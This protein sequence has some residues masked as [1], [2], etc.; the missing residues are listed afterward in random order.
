L[1]DKK[2]IRIS[3]GGIYGFYDTGI[4]SIIKNQYK[5]SNYIFSG[6]SAGA[7]NCLFMS[8]KKD[9]NKLIKSIHNINI[10][11]NSI[12][13]LQSEL[14][15]KILQHHRS[16]DFDLK[17]IFISVC[18]LD[19][20]QFKNFIYTDFV[21]LE[22]V[23]DCCIASSNIPFITGNLINIYRNK[24]T[25]DGGFLTHQTFIFKKP[26]FIIGNGIWGKKRNITSLFS[27][28]NKDLYSIYSEGILDTNLNTNILDTEFDK[29]NYL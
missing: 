12:K 15:N 6:A 14:K 27:K 23:I 29:K 24:I 11:F 19:N 25:F 18:V 10:N 9:I 5:L 26:D 13:Q 28:K 21:N 20:L 4:C 2:L 16:E 1:L 8:Y 7:W 22:D 3:P 17:K